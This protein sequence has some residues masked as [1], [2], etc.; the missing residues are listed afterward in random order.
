MLLTIP[1]E[2]LNARVLPAVQFNEVAF[3]VCATLEESIVQCCRCHQLLRPPDVCRQCIEAS[4][5]I[6]NNLYPNYRLCLFAILINLHLVRLGRKGDHVI[7]DVIG[8]LMMSCGVASVQARFED[9]NPTNP[10]S[11]QMVAQTKRK[12]SLI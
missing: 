8:N 2:R 4:V 10:V 11:R 5:V 6:E 12:K 9:S 7:Y 3:S 1:P